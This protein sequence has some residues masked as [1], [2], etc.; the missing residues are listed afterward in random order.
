MIDWDRVE[1]LRI[2]VGDEDFIEIA[3][4]FLEELQDAVATLDT[5]PRDQTLC[6]ALHGI[7]G[8]AANLG[9]KAVSELCALGERDP[10]TFAVTDL[11]TRMHTS[12]EA[13]KG[14]YDAI[15]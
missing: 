15:P 13:L 10:E 11:R 3:G 12:I 1:E 8:S 2:E 7:K 4:L 14:R 5:L 6:D 9:F